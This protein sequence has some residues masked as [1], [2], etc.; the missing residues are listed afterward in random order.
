MNMHRFST[1]CGLSDGVELCNIHPE[2]RGAI[3]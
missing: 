1:G 2:F 3:V